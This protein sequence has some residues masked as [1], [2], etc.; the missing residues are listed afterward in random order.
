MTQALRSFAP[1]FE[2]SS[3]RRFGSTSQPQPPA[4]PRLASL[5][6]R[7]IN[8]LRL[9]DR[10]SHLRRIARSR[11]IL[12]TLARFRGE[13]AGARAFAYLRTVDPHTFEEVVLSSI[14]AAGFVVL[15]NRRYTGDGGVDGRVLLPGTFGKTLA[16]QVKRYRSA[17]NPSHVGDFERAIR[18]GGHAGGLLVHCGRTGPLTRLA[19]YGMPIDL[20]SGSALLNLLL[21]QR[22][23][24]INLHHFKSQ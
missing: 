11:R 14:E 23:P 12:T 6:S 10:P 17:I 9:L 8:T 4:F 1:R 21:R 5:V 3:A 18:A 20:V 2:T 15:R 22:A 16:V 19:L 24:L 7:A 13:G